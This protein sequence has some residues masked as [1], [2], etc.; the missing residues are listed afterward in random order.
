[1]LILDLNETT[2]V[3]AMV[4]SVLWFWH[5]VWMEDGHED[6]WSLRLKVNVELEIKKD[7]E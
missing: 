6:C 1:M 4:Y 5:W 2:D 7:L 3:L